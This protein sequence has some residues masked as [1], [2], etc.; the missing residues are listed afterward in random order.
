[1][2]KLSFKKFYAFLK[3]N[4]DNVIIPSMD[5][6]AVRVITSSCCISDGRSRARAYFVR[7]LPPSPSLR[8]TGGRHASRGSEL[9][10][11]PAATRAVRSSGVFMGEKRLENIR[12]C[13]T[14]PPVKYRCTSWLG[15][16]RGGLG[17]GI[18]TREQEKPAL[19]C[20]PKG[21]RGREAQLQRARNWLQACMGRACQEAGDGG[22]MCGQLE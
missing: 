21:I 10:S 18:V 22:S 3:S 8:R 9:R 20:T 1:L 2:R 11:T 4:F 7:R 17:K 6:L 13:E 12:F 14:N 15:D 19:H 16:W 5:F